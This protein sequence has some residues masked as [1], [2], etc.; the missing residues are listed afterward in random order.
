L[1]IERDREA[2]FLYQV[3]MGNQDAVR[4]CQI[5][6]RVSQVWD[7]LID[8]D[9]V[10]PE[11]INKTFWQL[12]IELPVNPF[13]RL[14]FNHL[15]PLLSQYIIDWLDANTMEKDG[16]EGQNMAFVLR[17]SVSSLAIQCALLIGG[18]D[19]MRKVSVEIRRFIFDDTLD[20]Y[21]KNL[22]NKEN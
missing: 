11:D 20:E 14:H 3:F 15:Q 19:Y 17:D 12:L 21:K 7:D 2:E 8:G 5:I 6:F 13:Y 4:F 18:Y 9:P 1:Q 10:L 22:R 16:E